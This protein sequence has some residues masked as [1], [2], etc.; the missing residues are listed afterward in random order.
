MSRTFLPQEVIRR[1]RDGE[2]LSDADIDSMI[3]GI[4]DGTIGEGQIAAFAMAVFFQGMTMRERIRMTKAMTRS[5][6]IL[7]WKEH[8][9]EGP[10]VDKHSTG[11]VG[12][13]T[14]LMLAP[15]LAACGAYVPMISGR[16]LGHT[17]GTLDKLDA[18]PDMNT[19]PNRAAF[20]NTVQDVG[21]AIIGQ[22]P[23]LAPADRRIY[24]VRDV[25]ATVESIDL[26]TASILSKKLAAGLSGLV[27]DVK[28]GS[29]AFMNRTE[30]ARDLA[31]AIADVATGSGVPT[32]CLITDM[33]EVLGSSVGNSV[34][35]IEALDFL[36]GK[37]REP[38]TLELIM[39]LGREML[40]LAG[41]AKS[42]Q[43]ADALLQHSLESG[44]AAEK[45]G[46]M[47][48]ALGAPAN[49]VE[50]YD[51]LL[52]VAP[53]SLEV[54]TKPG[55]I[56]DMDC[57]A[58]GVALVEMGGGRTRAD[59]DIDHGVGLTGF[60]NVGGFMDEETPLCTIHARTK[61]QAEDAAKI[62]ESA[63]NVGQH[64]PTLLPVICERIAGG[65]D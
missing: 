17:G 14:S 5:G 62:I 51:T 59:Q 19:T 50:K 15:M 30:D 39:N 42:D 10:V 60:L 54:F 46:K 25:T 43:T 55:F 11:G 7:D 41:L 37:N 13:K 6:T 27:M 65:E 28:H 57:R 26:I 48:A 1:K 21:C 44:V 45:F 35:V 56:R 63:V 36:T 47:A 16:G 3:Q 32:T 64:K 24:S 22:T 61:K 29:G 52:D 8:G 9:L 49:L 2:C 23:D 40:L 18:I 34:E 31:Q 20:M 12:D 58:I 53:V 33:N 38:R 4:T